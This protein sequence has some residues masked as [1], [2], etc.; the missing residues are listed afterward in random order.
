VKC[1]KRTG[2]MGWLFMHRQMNFPFLLVTY[3]TNRVYIFFVCELLQLG[4]RFHFNKFWYWLFRAANL[5]HGY[6][7]APY[8]DCNGKVKDWVITYASP[9][10]GWDSLKVKLEFKWVTF[11]FR[12]LQCY[13]VIVHSCVS[14]NHITVWDVWT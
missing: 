9:F 14:C 8:F 12:G 11:P 4:S 3:L 10:F 1:Y 6:W 13:T 5:D 7:T 2:H